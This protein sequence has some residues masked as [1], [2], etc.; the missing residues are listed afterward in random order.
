MQ[1][2]T[3]GAMVQVFLLAHGIPTATWIENSR[4]NN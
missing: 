3:T 4:A 1:V 2:Y